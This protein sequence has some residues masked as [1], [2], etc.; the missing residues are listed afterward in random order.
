MVS[1]EGWMADFLEKGLE[2]VCFLVE[3]VVVVAAAEKISYM[4]WTKIP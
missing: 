3:E 1:L 2:K 4:D